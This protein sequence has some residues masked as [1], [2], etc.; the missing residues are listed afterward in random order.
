MS[1]AVQAPDRPIDAP[2]QTPAGR[3]CLSVAE[4]ADLIRVSP[5][6]IYTLAHK[7]G[8]P[9][10]RLLGRRL[11]RRADLE[12]WIAAQPVDCPGTEPLAGEGNRP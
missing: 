4:A 8:L 3:L 6:Q 7:A 11:V 5:R 2:D 1:D 10:I 9:T 12:R